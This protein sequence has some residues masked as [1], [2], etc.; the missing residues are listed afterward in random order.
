MSLRIRQVLALE[1]VLVAAAAAGCQ[2]AAAPAAHPPLSYPATKK[3][4]TVEDHFGTKVADPYRWMEDLDSKD[5]SEWVAAQNRLTEEELSKLP[6][7]DRFK[8][9]I[10]ELW[11]YP[12][13][14]LP[15]REGGRYFYTKNSG[16]QRQ[17][18]LYVRASL[19]APPTLVIDPNLISPDGSLSLAQWGASPDGK[20]VAYGLSEGGADWR[21]LHVRDVDASKDFDDEVKWM[22]FSNLSWTKDSKGFFYSRFAEPPKGRVLEAALSGQTIY[23]HRVGTPQRQD[24]LIYERKDLP[25]W[26]LT[27]TTTEDGRYLLI[28]MSKGS[29]N[30]NRLYYS[31]LG[32][33]NRPKIGAPV[34][35]IVEEDGA[36][37][38]PFGNEG[39][40][41]YLRKIGRAHV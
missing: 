11:N 41:L 8:R 28:S 30:S 3:G 31:D 21:T 39:P 36:E 15:V 38:L 18:P 33:P 37:F 16:L 4:E 34:K 22:R 17:A 5:V 35:P 13:T 10:T 1:A 20:L 32:D 24:T 7:R 27:G 9:R 2:Q 25:A 12:R 29:D 6:A 26:F 14:G 23:Y 40:V 19:T